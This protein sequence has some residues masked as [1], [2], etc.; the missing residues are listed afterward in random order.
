VAVCPSGHGLNTKPSGGRNRKTARLYW[1]RTPDCSTR[2]SRNVEHLD[3]YVSGRVLRRLNDPA[4]LASL[5]AERG[6]SGVSEQI[7]AL[8]R[9]KAAARDQLENLA[10]LPEAVDPVLLARSLASFDRRIAE[11]RERLESTNRVRLLR[12]MAGVSAEE[13]EST[14]LEIRSATV[15]AVF[16]VTVLPATWRGPGFDPACVRLDPVKD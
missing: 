9:R 4:F 6:D 16:R 11:L 8:E 2:V 13:W 7:G 12:R 15:A 1:C 14:S 10:D 3:R 5:D